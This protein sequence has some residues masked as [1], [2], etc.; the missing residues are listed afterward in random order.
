MTT[1]ATMPNT[2]MPA[3][4]RVVIPCSV[5]DYHVL[6]WCAGSAGCSVAEL[7]RKALYVATEVWRGQV[8]ARA[9]GVEVPV[10]EAVETP[11]PGQARDMCDIVLD[12]DSR[13][14]GVVRVRSKCKTDEDLRRALSGEIQWYLKPKRELMRQHGMLA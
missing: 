2:S 10:D 13:T 6:Q 14:L 5:M 12:I 3:R 11:A 4:V 9:K 1:A 8:A 7:V